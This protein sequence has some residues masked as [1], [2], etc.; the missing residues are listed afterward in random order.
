MTT[1]NSDNT[2]AVIKN[3]LPSLWR[4]ALQITQNNH[5]AEDLVQHTCLRALERKDQYQDLQKPKSWLFRIAQNIWKNEL[6]SRSIRERGFIK[7]DLM[8][9][10]PPANVDQDNET[11]DSWLEHTEIVNA[12]QALPEAQRMVLVLVAVNGFSYCETAEILDI[13]I[14]TVMSRLARARVEIG[15]QF[16]T[17]NT[18]QSRFKTAPK[19]NSK[20]PS[21]T[22]SHVGITDNDRTVKPV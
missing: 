10:D 1:S 15:R 14:G 5:D 18:Q 8:M 17:N 6:R 4:F 19:T 21:N 12:V 2:C 22:A 16:N 11:P 20:Q 9:I 13:P 7:S 3:G